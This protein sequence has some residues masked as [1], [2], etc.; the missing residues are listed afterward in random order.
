M[1]RTGPAGRRAPGPVT[2]AEGEQ[3][4]KVTSSTPPAPAPDGSRGPVAV[5]LRP[6]EDPELVRRVSGAYRAKYGLD[7]P[8]PVESM[9]GNE[10]AATTMRLTDVGQVAQLPA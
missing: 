1:P 10:A 8:G 3:P 6:V 9:N 5:V 2:S 4:A 7:W